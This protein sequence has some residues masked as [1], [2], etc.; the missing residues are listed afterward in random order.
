[1]LPDINPLLLVGFFAGSCFGFVIGVFVFA[2]RSIGE[3]IPRNHDR[4]Q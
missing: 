3:D 2:A 4:D 1:M